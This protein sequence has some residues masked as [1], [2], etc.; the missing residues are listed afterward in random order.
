LN[1]L[2][3]RNPTRLRRYDFS[4]SG[5]YFVTFNVTG[6]HRM[7]GTVV[8]AGSTRPPT[9]QTSY[10][11]LSVHGKIVDNAIQMLLEKFNCVFVDKY[12]VMPNHV[13]MIIIIDN[14]GQVDPAPILSSVVGYLKFQTMKEIKIRDFWQRSFHDHIIRNAESHNK[15]RRYIHINPSIWQHDCHYTE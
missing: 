9:K 3:I 1:E 6:M 5:A 7:L 11:E 12:I 8:G 4:K 14:H 15:I 2:P 13:H 10:V